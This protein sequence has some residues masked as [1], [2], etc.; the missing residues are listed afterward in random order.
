M[1]PMVRSLPEILVVVVFACQGTAL[2]VDV[3]APD[4]KGLFDAALALRKDGDG[5]G[6][7]AKL[8]AALAQQPG[9]ALAALERAELLLEAGEPGRAVDDV[10]LAVE[11]LPGNPRSQRALGRL[12]EDREDIACALSAYERSLAVREDPLVRRRHALLAGAAGDHAKAVE[13]WEVLRVQDPSD[14]AAR[15]ELALAYDKADRPASAEAEFDALVTL[16]PG[17]V[18]IVR[19]FVEFLERQGKPA[20]AR[21]LIAKVEP[22][23]APAGPAKGERR[24]RVLPRSSR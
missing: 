9:F 2:A 17:N 11:N 5:P 24:M 22:A 6:A 20:K 23:P 10:K 4:A 7:I 3:A 19:R 15:L 18:P 8:D 21:E 16:A 12:C 14:V 13:S 1:R